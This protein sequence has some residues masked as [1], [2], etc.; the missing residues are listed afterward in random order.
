MA[1]ERGEQ[2]DAVAHAVRVGVAAP[3]AVV[4]AFPGEEELAGPVGHPRPHAAVCASGTPPPSVGATA[5][6]AP[7]S[8]RV[9]VAPD[10]PAGAIPLVGA[11]GVGGGLG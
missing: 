8:S 2:R 11:V 6:A 5:A 3:L 10:V 7:S 1:L 9:G 4:A